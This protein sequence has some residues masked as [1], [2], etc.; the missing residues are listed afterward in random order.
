MK[1]QFTKPTL[2]VELSQET[3][4]TFINRPYISS[5]LRE[6]L[7]GANVLLIPNEGYGGKKELVYFPSG[8]AELF[9]FL[10][11]RKTEN[12]NVD[13]CIEE[14]DYKEVALHFDWLMLASFVVTSLVA[15]LI[16]NLLTE[17]IKKRQGK[18]E[19]DTIVK[20]TLVVCDEKEGRYVCLSYEGPA[21]KYH[22]TMLNAI[23]NLNHPTTPLL[24]AKSE[25]KRR[26]KKKR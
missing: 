25:R 16:V 23:S 7:S 12:L 11:E 5:E 14:K 26:A 3:F 18:R 24:S 8:T 19:P 20:H 1:T 9:H 17:Y 2:I 15:P 6:R 4:Q 13:I 21:P 22:D 10:E